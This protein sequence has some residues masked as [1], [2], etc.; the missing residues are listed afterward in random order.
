MHFSDAQMERLFPFHFLTNRDGRLISCGGR[1]TKVIA[2]PI[3]EPILTTFE[4]IE[5]TRVGGWFPE[6]FK[7]QLVILKHRDGGA[8][9]RGEVVW[10]EEEEAW[11]FLGSP[12]VSNSSDLKRLG[13]KFI[14]FPAHQAVAEF[15]FMLNAQESHIK[16]KERLASELEE[17]NRALAYREKLLDSLVDNLP[18]GGAV[19]LREDG[20]VLLAGGTDLPCRPFRGVG[21]EGESLEEIFGERAAEIQ[22]HLRECINSGFHSRFNYEVNQCV[23]RCSV[24]YLRHP[25]QLRSRWLMIFQNITEEIH[26]QSQAERLQRLDSV[27]LLAGGIAHDFNNYLAS[28]LGNIALARE[29]PS[30]LH[31][32][33]QDAENACENARQLTR[34]LLTFSKGGDPVKEIGDLGIVLKKAARFSLSGS[35]MVWSVERSQEVFLADFDSGQISQVVNN[36]CVNALQATGG[37]GVV[38]IYLDEVTLAEETNLLEPGPYLRICVSDNGP[39]I[40]PEILNQIWNPYFTTKKE[41]SGL[42]LA[43]C[44][45]IISR[46]GGHISL[47]SVVGQG[48]MFKIL[49]PAH[50]QSELAA[51]PGNVID[52]SIPAGR[53]LVMDDQVPIRIIARRILEKLGQ[54]VV[55]VEEGSEA[56]GVYR[57]SM[58]NGEPFDLVLLDMTIPGGMG[59]EETLSHLKSIQPGIFAVVCSGY[60]DGNNLGIYQKMGFSASLPKPFTPDQV[61]QVLIQRAAALTLAA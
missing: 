26:H 23:Y 31:E 11:L 43:T 13:L 19:I 58:G 59:G 24:S 21:D 20:T 29:E 2:P 41:G 47:E 6:R 9:L 22:A 38:R 17:Q 16:D 60:S 46:H 61:R 32:T 52:F 18:T 8:S 37:T 35:G 42:G 12:W 50:R 34:Q 10:M 36:L 49:L 39:G 30:L 25:N 27:G 48:T 55:T 1:L 7:H 4:L 15:L 5:P 3:G 33:L 51:S 54:Q 57:E 53:V 56:I 14:D 40:A 28:I 44:H 45:S